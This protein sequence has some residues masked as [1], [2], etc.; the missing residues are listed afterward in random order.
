M[1]GDGGTDFMDFHGIGTD[2]RFNNP[3]QSRKN[4]CNPYIHH[5]TKMVKEPKNPMNPS[6]KA[7][8][9]FQ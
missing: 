5:H 2:F 4:P 7:Y 8:Q 1:E 6:L 9:G 3:Y